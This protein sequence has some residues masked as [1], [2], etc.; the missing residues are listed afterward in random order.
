MYM[1]VGCIVPAFGIWIQ[2]KGAVAM[3]PGEA[4]NRAI[5]QVSGHR[6]ENVKIF[7]SI[8]KAKNNHDA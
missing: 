5:S 1:A 6:Y 7:E 4:M 3:L 2:F 8:K